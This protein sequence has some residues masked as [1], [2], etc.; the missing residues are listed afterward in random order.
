MLMVTA[1]VLLTIHRLVWTLWP[2]LAKKILSPCAS[3]FRA[4]S[5]YPLSW[6]CSTL[7]TISNYATA[8]ITT[9]IYAI[10]F[11]FLFRRRS[12]WRKN[13]EVRVTL[14]VFCFCAYQIVCFIVWEFVM[15]MLKSKQYLACI[16]LVMWVIWNGASALLYMI[17][18][19]SFR[20]DLV[21][22]VRS[23][24]WDRGEHKC[25]RVIPMDSVQNL[26][27]AVA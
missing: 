3:K 9:F 27:K 6:I 24:G 5:G 18:S 16:N 15:P 8:I 12:N 26:P 22:M 19:V 23:V 7:D 1:T 4:G 25:N 14:L 2:M 13:R 11:G 21:N 10:I 17:F 20:H